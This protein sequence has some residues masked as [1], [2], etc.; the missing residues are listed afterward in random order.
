MKVGLWYVGSCCRL[1]KEEA[2]QRQPGL[3][4]IRAWVVVGKTNGWTFFFKA[5]R[6]FTMQV[7]TATT[8]SV[9]DSGKPSWPSMS[10]RKLLAPGTLGRMPKPIHRQHLID[11]P[12]PTAIQSRLLSWNQWPYVVRRGQIMTGGGALRTI[13]ANGFDDPKTVWW[14]LNLRRAILVHQRGVITTSEPGQPTRTRNAGL[15]GVV[16]LSCLCDTSLF[17]D[18]A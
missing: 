4:Y 17:H 7:V 13:S 6:E 5:K 11:S 1:S 18:L 2:S 10:S 3:E 15:N 14:F 8:V 12:I 16:N 9:R